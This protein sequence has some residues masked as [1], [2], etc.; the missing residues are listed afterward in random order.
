MLE[1]LAVGW[2]LSGIIAG[3]IASSKH[4]S[5]CGFLILGLIFGPLAI[6]AAAV[7]SRDESAV[8]RAAID[9]GDMDLCPACRMPVH[10]LA[11]KCPSCRSELVPNPYPP[12]VAERLGRF[13]GGNSSGG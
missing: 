9:R 13:F 1:T 3:M 8:T 6:L 11:S 12:S 2:L 5:G 4:R 7:M 10:R